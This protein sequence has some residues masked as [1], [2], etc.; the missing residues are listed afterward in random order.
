[1]WFAGGA[2]SSDPVDL[3]AGNYHGGITNL[4]AKA[5][6]AAAA[7]FPAVAFT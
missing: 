2:D 1:M 5:A 4:T 6:D 7:E 3:P